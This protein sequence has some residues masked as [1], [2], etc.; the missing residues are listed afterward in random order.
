MPRGAGGNVRFIRGKVNNHGRVQIR[1]AAKRADTA[2]IGPMT[3]DGTKVADIVTS[4]DIDPSYKQ[5]VLERRRANAQLL[6]DAPALKREVE[7]YRQALTFAVD[8]LESP[9]GVSGEVLAHILRVALDG[10]ECNHDWKMV[11]GGDAGRV[12]RKC[13]TFDPA[14]TPSNTPKDAQSHA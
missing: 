5:G 7:R 9:H 6:A 10:T 11:M 4:V 13:Q 8:H 12:C 3:P 2:W 1:I 14:G